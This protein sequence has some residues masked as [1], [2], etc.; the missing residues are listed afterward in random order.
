MVGM[1]ALAAHWQLGAVMK[2]AHAHAHAHAHTHTLSL[3]V[4]LHVVAKCRTDIP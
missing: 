4:K 2:H 1:H 3:E